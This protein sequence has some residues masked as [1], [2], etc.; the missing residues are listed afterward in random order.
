[1]ENALNFTIRLPE[2]ARQALERAA[3]AEDR[4]VTALARKIIT[5][6]LRKRLEKRE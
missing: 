4:P 5:D 3:K 1:M 6:W 2:K